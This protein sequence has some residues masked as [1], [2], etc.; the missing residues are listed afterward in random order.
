MKDFRIEMG[1]EVIDRVT[2]FTGV[3]TSRADFI[4]GCDQYFVQP[5]VDKEGKKQEAHWFDD[6]RLEEQT[7]KPVVIDERKKRT[8]GPATHSMP[9]R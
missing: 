6:L 7:A 9:S 4:S 8:G 3:V 1:R 5:R 2:G